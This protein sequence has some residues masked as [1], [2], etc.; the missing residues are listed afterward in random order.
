MS[1]QSYES[2][3][4][5]A[6]ANL[7]SATAAPKPTYSIDGQRVEHAEYLV[8]LQRLVEWCDAQIANL[9]P[10]EVATQAGSP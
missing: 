6:L 2:I 9:N 7:E 1:Q 8:R 10:I 4:A 3:R 5:N